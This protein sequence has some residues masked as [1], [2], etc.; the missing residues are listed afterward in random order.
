[1]K[2]LIVYKSCTGFTER[3]ARL[4]GEKIGAETADLKDISV[5]QMGQ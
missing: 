5:K 2:T 1:M 4:I 3:Y